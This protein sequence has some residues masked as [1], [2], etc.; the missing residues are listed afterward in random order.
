MVSKI[1]PLDTIRPVTPE[2]YPE[3]SAWM[4]ARGASGLRPDL[5]PPQGF[6]APGI[7]AGFMITTNTG[8]AILEHF[9]TNSEA[10]RALRSEILGRIAELL[11][12][13]GQM[14]GMVAFMAITANAKVEA[15]C[16]KNGFKEQP[17]MKLWL[18]GS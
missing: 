15:L 16:V 3:I 11:I 12:K 4:R 13:A 8:V 5:T 6:I 1:H 2:D 10:P 17:G 18:R 7:A 14:S 9:A